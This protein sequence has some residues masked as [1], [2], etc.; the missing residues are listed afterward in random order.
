MKVEVSYVGS[1]TFHINTNDNQ[2]GGARN[3]NVLSVA[4]LQQAQ[5]NPSYLTQAVTNPFAGLI[6]NNA[7]LNGATIQRQQLLLPYPQFQQV[8]V[9]QESVGRLWYDS[10]QVNVEKRYSSSL[11]L[12]AAYT[13]SKNLDATAFLNNQDAKPTKVLSASDRPQ[14]LV[15][16]GVYQLPFGKGR[17]YLGSVNR[18]W[19]QLVGGWEY[20]F[21]R[22]PAIRHAALFSWQCESDRQPSHQ[23]RQLR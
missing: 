14:R 3:L 6:P 16:S 8:L 22:H 10:V 7:A 15:V 20:N 1:H 2:A 4:Q 11:V 12:A 23:Q 21:H 5:Q 18:G 13:F 9:A 19:E 17:K